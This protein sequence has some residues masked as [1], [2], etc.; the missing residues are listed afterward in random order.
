MENHPP[1]LGSAVQGEGEGWEGN[2]HPDLASSKGFRL[3]AAAA[4]SPQQLGASFLGEF[5]EKNF[6]PN[7]TEA[8][9]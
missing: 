8:N 6:P 2:E 7:C 4:E 3:P 5:L 9:Q 1:C